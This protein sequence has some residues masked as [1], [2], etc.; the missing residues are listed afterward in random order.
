MRITDAVIAGTLFETLWDILSSRVAL[1]MYFILLFASIAGMIVAVMKLTT[2][3]SAKQASDGTGAGDG[4][5][6]GDTGLKAEAADGAEGGMLELI[7]DDDITSRFHTLI[8]YDRAALRYVPPKHDDAIT[9]PMI[10]R[11]FRN[12]A[13]CRLGLFY[14]EEDVRKFVAGLGVS[15]LMVMQGLSGTGKTSM[16]TAFGSYLQNPSTVISVQ[17]MWKERSD[18]IGYFNEFTKRFSEGTLLKKLYEARYTDEIY[19]IVLDEM[20]IARVEYYFADFLSQMEL[21]PASRYLEVVS[22]TWEDDPKLL[23]RGML[24]IPENVWFIGTANND[25]S[26]FAISDKVYDRAMVMN[27][28]RKADLFEPERVDGDRISFSRFTELTKEAKETYHMSEEAAEKVRKID[29]FLTE[30]FRVTYGNRIRR[31]M[32]EYIPVYLACGGT[33]TEAVDDMLAKKVLRKL[34]GL[35]PVLIRYSMDALE[36]VFETTFGLANMP[37]CRDSLDRLRRNAS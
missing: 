36:N 24:R 30:R 28:D 2:E 7:D 8:Q 14:S 11:N 23:E 3:Q 29:E 5:E 32:E 17:P 15:H 4:T 18:I 13:A 33:E 21:N 22:D 27:L 20:N 34:D 12:Y 10:C 31:Q 26:T 35:S 1:M 6:D 16:A 25:D 19:V 9:L 37:L